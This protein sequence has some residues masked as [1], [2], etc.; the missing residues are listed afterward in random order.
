MDEYES[1]S[2]VGWA[3]MHGIKIPQQHFALKRQGGGGLICEGG[4][5][6]GTLRYILSNDLLS[7]CQHGFRPGSSTQEALLLMTNDWHCLLNFNKQVAVYYI[8]KAFVSVPHHLL[9]NSP[10]VWCIWS[11]ANLLEE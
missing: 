7:N 2:G 9:I 4:R 6:C 5:I 11:S 3:L 8:L 1:S 10:R